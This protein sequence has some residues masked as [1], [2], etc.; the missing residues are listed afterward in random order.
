MYSKQPTLGP[1]LYVEVLRHAVAYCLPFEACS[2][3]CHDD[4]RRAISTNI[5]L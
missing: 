1:W 4:S 2:D 5:D 3:T